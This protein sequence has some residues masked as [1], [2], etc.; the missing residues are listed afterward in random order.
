MSGEQGGTI[1]G[2]AKRMKENSPSRAEP[3]AIGGAADDEWGELDVVLKKRATDG[4]ARGP[5]WNEVQAKA[6]AFYQKHP[7]DPRVIQARK[8]EL[9]ARINEESKGQSLSKE[10]QDRVHVF[11]Q[12]SKIPSKDRFDVDAA[13]KESELRFSPE[14]TQA[15]RHKLRIDHAR[16]LM[17]SYED[18]SRGYGYLLSIAKHES[19]ESGIALAEEILKS[20]AS[21]SLKLGAQR[22][23]DQSKLKGSVL[24]IEG[25]DLKRL[26]GKP[27]LIYAWSTQQPHVLKLIGQVLTKFEVHTIGINIDEDIEQAKTYVREKKIPGAQ[28]YDRGMDGSICSQLN[29]TMQGS[30]YLLDSQGVLLDTRGHSGTFLKVAKMFEQEGGAK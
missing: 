17:K 10:T 2:D 11:L 15:G 12:D 24:S 22:L 9:T 26:R 28:F 19:Q 23:I 25:I 4:N 18:D 5:D 16:Q 7:N 8:I 3:K 30:I 6:Q 20:K 14:K 21:G 27:V 1:V 29:L 13:V